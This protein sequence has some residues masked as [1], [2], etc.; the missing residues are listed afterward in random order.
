MPQI[1]FRSDPGALTPLHLSAAQRLGKICELVG[2]R[3][4][5]T[6]KW[7]GRIRTT[8]CDGNGNRTRGHE[9]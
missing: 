7:H 4:L 8:I 1:R 3:A 5:A 6:G 9:D 2:M